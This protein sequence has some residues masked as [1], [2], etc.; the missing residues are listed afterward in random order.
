MSGGAPR[1]VLLYDAEC[2]LCRWGVARILAWDRRRALRPV[3][4]QG[5]EGADLLHDLDPGARMDSWHLIPP[6]T[7]R[8][9]A[10]AAVAPL[11]RLLPGG[12]PAAQVAERHPEAV[13]RAYRAVARRR[14]TLGRLVSA[15]AARRARRRI[16][17]RA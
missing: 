15:G 7:R 11:L 6:G 2:G 16:A 1:A 9:S 13:E 3:A 5:P 10:G 4:I 14:R 8:S 12:S 17:G